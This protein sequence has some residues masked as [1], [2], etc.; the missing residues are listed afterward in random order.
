MINYLEK[1][2]NLPKDLKDKISAPHVMKAM[3]E[4]E[5]NYGVSLAALIM[6]VMVKDLHVEEVHNFLVDTL[7]MEKSKALLLFEELKRR[8]FSEISNYLDYISAK[9]DIVLTAEDAMMPTELDS[10]LDIVN[11]KPNDELAQPSSGKG[12]D[13]YFSIEDEDEVRKQAQDMSAL[14]RREQIARQVEG[15][16]DE[17]IGEINI[18]FSS[19]DMLRRLRQILK[20]YLRG[21]RD[22]IDTRQALERDIET[23]GLGMEEEI[24]DDILKIVDIINKDEAQHPGRV[25]VP[26]KFPLPEDALKKTD[27]EEEIRFGSDSLPRD[28]MY[29]FKQLASRKEES[30]NKDIKIDTS[31]ERGPEIVGDEIDEVSNVAVTPGSA[32]VGRKS[33]VKVEELLKADKEAQEEKKDPNLVLD[34]KKSE[35]AFAK[36]TETEASPPPSYEPQFIEDDEE[37]ESDSFHPGTMAKAR[38]QA[39]INIDYKADVRPGFEGLNKV[40]MEDVKKVA[41]LGGPLE[42]VHSMSPLDFRR[43]SRDPKEAS[44]KILAMFKLLEEE[45]FNKR[46]AG[47]KAWRQSPINKLY[48]SIGQE[49]LIKKKEIAKIIEERKA[50]NGDY[51]SQAEFDAIM[52]LNKKL[53]F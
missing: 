46:L 36:E 52:E 16:I 14:D 40:K 47:V 41:K 2:N 37:E 5:A 43:L 13:F 33:S 45:G 6:R 19:E 31:E 42:E 39:P 18:I 26:K 7:G 34:L 44:N 30:A 35:P 53:R 9:P 11:I 8:I 25:Y 21:V 20:T 51:L 27:N 4:M 1:Y 32:V 15:K 3:H 24:A 17:I 22:K 28:A 10:R 29:D 12:A 23:G 48:L 38:N 50:A 49:S